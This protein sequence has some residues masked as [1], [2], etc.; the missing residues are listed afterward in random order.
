MWAAGVLEGILTIEDINNFYINVNSDNIGNTENGDLSE[1]FEKIDQ[2]IDSQINHVDFFKN[3]NQT[4]L[5]YWTQITL[6]KA[7]LTGVFNGYNSKASKK[8]TLTDFYFIN[9][10][11]QLS[12]LLGYMSHKKKLK[13]SKE[14]IQT[15]LSNKKSKKLDVENLLSNTNSLNLKDFWIKSLRKSHCSVFVKTIMD[16]ENLGFQ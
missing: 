10:D 4:A 14:T 7:Q 8:L 3:L 5:N 6:S 12:E 2:H 16:S 11:G 1:F 9:A 13:S 15:Q